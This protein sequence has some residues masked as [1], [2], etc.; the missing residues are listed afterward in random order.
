MEPSDAYYKTKRNLL[1]FVS[2]LLLAIFAGFR[3]AQGEQK[4]S[5]LPFQLERPESL[6][7]ILFV[8]VLFNL[9]QFGLQW[10]AQNTEVQRNKFYRIDFMFCSTV[11][12]VSILC[13]L[14][15][16]ASPLVKFDPTINIVELAGVVGAVAA[17]LA[18]SMSLLQVSEKFG[19]WIKRKARS[20]NEELSKILT[21]P[22][23]EWVLVYNPQSASG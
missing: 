11:G 2:C 8:V 15:S 18:A 4:I 13:Y 19:K 20:E 10:A 17:A 22:D 6:S 14:W 5:V 23:E 21:S 9:S 16:L 12:A 1:V 3:I 7:T